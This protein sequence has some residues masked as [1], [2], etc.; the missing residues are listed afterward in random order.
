[1]TGLTLDS[2]DLATFCDI[3][4]RVRRLIFYGIN[5]HGDRREQIS[6]ALLLG[7]A[8][9]SRQEHHGKDN[10]ECAK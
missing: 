1:M 9:A 5:R 7:W 4:R 6:D 8:G 10:D 3:R 2:I